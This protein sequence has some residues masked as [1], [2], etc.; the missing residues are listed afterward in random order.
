MPRG[1]DLDEPGGESVNVT[2]TVNGIQKFTRTGTI[3]TRVGNSGNYRYTTDNGE[4]IMYRRN[5]GYKGLAK[6][7]LD[8]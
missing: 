2:V 7:L 1:I 3:T 8:A 5:S 6:E 4:V